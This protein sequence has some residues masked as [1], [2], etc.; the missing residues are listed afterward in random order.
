MA[1]GCEHSVSHLPRLDP[2]WLAARPSTPLFCEENVW[3]VCRALL[4]DDDG[5]RRVWA[6][7][8][9]NATRTV[10]MWAQQAAVVDPIVWDYHVVTVVEGADGPVVLDVDCRAGT[11]LP[12]RG[13]LQASF[14]AGLRSDVEPRFRIIPAR[15][16]V[17]VL[18]SD[19]SH[20]RDD[21]GQPLQPFPPWQAP[22]A[23]RPGTLQRL[24][25]LD[26]HLAGDVFDA[27]RLARRFGVAHVVLPPF[28]D[29]P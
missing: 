22:N 2:A 7:F 5:D 24:I 8:V 18:A 3:Q 15:V 12:L 25:D 28:G 23:E 27:K 9:T 6:V 4:A 26:D 19:R 1:S 16:Y 11:V 20:M 17:D 14:R 29:A 13:W 21:D 10:A